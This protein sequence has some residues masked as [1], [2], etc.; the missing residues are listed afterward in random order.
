MLVAIA[1]LQ[2]RGVRQQA[3][4]RRL[5]ITALDVPEDWVLLLGHGVEVDGACL[6]GKGTC[7]EI[8]P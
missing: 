5:Q 2:H 1:L 4:L 3:P 6:L 7:K 8:S